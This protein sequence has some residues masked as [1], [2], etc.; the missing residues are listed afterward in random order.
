MNI[1]G[2]TKITTLD[3]ELVDFLRN[4]LVQ[5]K[6]AE[7]E[8]YGQ[9]N[10]RDKGCLDLLRTCFRVHPMWIELLE[11]SWLN[12]FVDSM[13][14]DTAILH[15]TFCLFNTDGGNNNLTR[16]KFHRDQPWIK[17]TRTSIAVFVLLEETHILN[18]ATEVVPGTHL[19]EK[20]PSE[21]FMEKHRVALMGCAGTVYGMDA[22]LWHRAG[23][24]QSGKTRPLLNLR[25]QLAFMKSPIDLC[26]AYGSEIETLSPLLKT[27]LGWNCRSMDS[28]EEAI[29]SPGKWKSGQYKMENVNVQK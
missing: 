14:S 25:Y 26:R 11:S 2:Y 7:I 3:R 24:N 23:N 17:D 22:A 19:F 16:N 21:K 15:D 13:L 20:Q 18:G 28:A 27:R 9:L 8:K 4:D 10:L 6:Q 1:Y 29:L 5:R 12:S